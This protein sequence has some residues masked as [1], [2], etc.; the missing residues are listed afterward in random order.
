MSCKPGYKERIIKLNDG[1]NI[2]LCVDENCGG[3][4]MYTFSD[5]ENIK[6]KQ[7]SL[8]FLKTSTKPFKYVCIREK[9]DNPNCK[10]DEK[11]NKLRQCIKFADQYIL[12]DDMDVIKITPS[13]PQIPIINVVNDIQKRV[14][15]ATKQNNILEN[16]CRILGGNWNNEKC[17]SLVELTNDE[18]SVVG[19]ILKDGMCIVDNQDTCSD[20][21]LNYV[22]N[23][24][25]CQKYA[26]ICL[27]MV[28]DR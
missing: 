5:N 9:D 17:T 15:C 21:T 28:G 7:F 18:C 24:Q 3:D 11:E 4:N 27:D 14:I 2:K 25:K 12:P 26:D 22:P 1:N 8:D 10:S 16:E 13:V 20:N 19:G 6:N 23:T